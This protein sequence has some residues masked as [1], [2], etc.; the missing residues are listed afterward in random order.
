[1]AFND[2]VNPVPFREALPAGFGDRASVSRAR[3]EQKC[4]TSR[5]GS[6]AEDAVEGGTRYFSIKWQG[7]GQGA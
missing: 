1:M 7:Q 3:H 6:G 5:Y 4:S 2:A